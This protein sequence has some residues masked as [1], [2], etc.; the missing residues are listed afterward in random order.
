MIWTRRVALNGSQ[1]DE[2]HSSVVIRG[3]EPGA[4]KDTIT[5][6]STGGPFGQRI[7]GSR[8]DS[9]DIVVKFALDIKRGN[10]QARAEALEAVNAWAAA[11][12]PERGGAWLTAGHKAERRIRVVLAQ[13][14]AEGDLWK[15]TEE[16]QLVFRACGVPYWDGELKSVSTD[17][18]ATG[19]AGTITIGGSAITQVNAYLQNT[20]GA[21][22]TQATIAIAGKNM[23]FS[24]IDLNAGETLTVD[25]TDDG[26]L[27]LRIRS[28]AGSYRSIMAYRSPESADDFTA[29]PGAMMYGFN[30]PRAGK[31]TVEWRDRYL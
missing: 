13:P 10:L 27:R 12:L 21:L 9:L 17:G 1:L 26:I 5:T 28:A 16:F 18:N 25:H 30:A 31:L 6:V 24:Q 20:S 19:A 2:V 8:R 7:T 3:I 23:R 11:A 29:Y 15:W 22:I 4:G 14:A